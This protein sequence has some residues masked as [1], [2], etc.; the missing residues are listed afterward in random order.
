MVCWPSR[1]SVIGLYCKTQKMGGKPFSLGQ[2]Q[3]N[4]LLVREMLDQVRGFTRSDG[5]LVNSEKSPHRSLPFLIVGCGGSL[6]PPLALTKSLQTPTAGPFLPIPCDQG[7]FR[8]P[9]ITCPKTPVNKTGHLGMT[10]VRVRMS[11][12]NPHAVGCHCIPNR[13]PSPPLFD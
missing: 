9:M 3:R 12:S 11:A 7:A 10:K 2:G 4:A 13:I 6:R 1:G 8:F 5:N